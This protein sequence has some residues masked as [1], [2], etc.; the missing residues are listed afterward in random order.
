MVAVKV[1]EGANG[2]KIGAY[3]FPDR[4]KP[5]LCVQRGNEVTIYGTFHSIEAGDLF[6]S[7]LAKLV[8]AV[9]GDSHGA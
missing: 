4:K 9:E 5:C 8:N 2:L 7:E 3:L 1:L 6:M